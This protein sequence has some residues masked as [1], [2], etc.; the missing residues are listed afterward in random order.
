MDDQPRKEYVLKTEDIKAQ[1][2]NFEDGKKILK[3]F[4]IN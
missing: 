2:D 1:L 4:M 3:I